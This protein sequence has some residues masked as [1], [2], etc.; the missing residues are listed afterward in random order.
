MCLPSCSRIGRQTIVAIPALWSLILSQMIRRTRDNGSPTVF[1]PLLRVKRCRSI[2]RTVLEEANDQ[3]NLYFHHYTPSIPNDSFSFYFCPP[4]SPPSLP[5]LPSSSRSLV[6]SSTSLIFS[7]YVLSFPSHQSPASS[8][9]L[10]PKLRPGR[11]HWA[12]ATCE[13]SSMLLP[14]GY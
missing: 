9:I 13:F 14:G 8:W 5:M 3:T 2:L 10:S 7:S 6:R 11:T 1:G 12:T 4:I